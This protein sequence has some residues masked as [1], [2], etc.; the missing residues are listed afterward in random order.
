MKSK[1]LLVSL[2]AALLLTGCGAKSEPAAHSHGNTTGASPQGGT[3]LN[4]AIPADVLALPLFDAKGSAFTLASL[5][6]KYVVLTNF[7]TSCSEIC[8]MNTANMRDISA[9]LSQSTIKDQVAVVEI[10]VDGERDTVSRLKAYQDLYEDYSFTVASGKQG[11][12]ETLWKYFGAPG[13]RMKYTAED[14]KNMPVDWQ[15]GKPNTYDVM[16][17]NLVMIISPDSEWRWLNLG[18]P[19]SNGEIPAKLKAFLTDEGLKNL[20]TPEEPNWSVSSVL[21]ALEQLTGAKI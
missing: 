12:L 2:A 3:F 8:P 7:L 17:P 6:G 18:N 20:V 10:S 11:D 15:T 16:H 9:A 19:K 13:E 14:M 21:Y 5:K 4:S 1:L